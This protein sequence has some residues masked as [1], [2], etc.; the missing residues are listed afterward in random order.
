LANNK[1]REIAVR[2]ASAIVEFAVKNKVEVIV[3]E[4]LICTARRKVVINKDYSFGET[5]RWSVV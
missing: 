3:L 4:H 5:K 1:N 2:T